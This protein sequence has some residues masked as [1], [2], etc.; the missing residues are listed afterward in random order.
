VGLP[1]WRESLGDP[2]QE[3]VWE[4]MSNVGAKELAVLAKSWLRAP[5]SQVLADC[6]GASYDPA[7]RAYI[8]LQPAA[9]SFRISASMTS[10]F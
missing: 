8:S 6:R 2:Y 3:K 9:P 5:S 7:Q 4:G 10:Q 1:A